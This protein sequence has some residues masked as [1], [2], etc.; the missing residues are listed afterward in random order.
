MLSEAKVTEVSRSLSEA[1]VSRSLSGVEANDI[2]GI[3]NGYKLSQKP[4]KEKL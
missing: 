1:E 4:P 3:A 2:F